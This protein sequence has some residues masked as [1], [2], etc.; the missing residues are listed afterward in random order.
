MVLQFNSLITCKCS[1]FKAFSFDLGF[2]LRFRSSMD[3]VY[4]SS[5]CTVPHLL[6]RDTRLLPPRTS[7]SIAPSSLRRVKKAQRLRVSSSAATNG[8]VSRA[9]QGASST[10]LEQLDIERGVC[11]PFRK[12]SPEIVRTH[13]TSLSLSLRFDYSV[14]VLS[15]SLSF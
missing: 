5:S 8:A 1:Q 7:G 2:Q 11:I 14:C 3:S 12:Y 9:L 6:R 4:A 13:S 15:A 10:A